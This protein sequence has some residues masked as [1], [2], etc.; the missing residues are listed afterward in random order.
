MKN[1]YPL[2]LL[3][4]LIVTGCSTPPSLEISSQSGDEIKIIEGSYCWKQKCVDKLTPNELLEKNNYKP[5]TLP[6]NS[7]VKVRFDKIPTSSDVHLQSVNQ[8]ESSVQQQ[9][10]D[11]RI[12]LPNQAGNYIYLIF[13]TW[14]SGSANY[15]FS[16]TIE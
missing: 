3:I 1:I 9:I 16:I 8:N 14:E 10:V 5:I 4:C 15:I 2:V 7:Y 12:T 13:A 6:A 11:N